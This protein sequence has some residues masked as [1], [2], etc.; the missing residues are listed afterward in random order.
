MTVGKGSSL[1]SNKIKAQPGPAAH[2]MSVTGDGAAWGRRPRLHFHIFLRLPAPGAKLPDTQHGL[3]LLRRQG[4]GM[5]ELRA[6]EY[7][8]GARQE[9]R[10]SGLHTQAPAPRA[11]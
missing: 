8:S 2:S 9:G 6:R 10:L 4:H 3:L 7:S 1:I 5:T 11:L